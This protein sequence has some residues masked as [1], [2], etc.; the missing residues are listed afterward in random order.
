MLEKVAHFN[1]LSEGLRE[2]LDKRISEFGKTVRYK[3]NIG[4]DNP[5]PEKKN[6]KILY[7]F[8]YT[9]DP[10]VFDINDTDEKDK[11]KSKRKKIGIIKSVDEKGL[12]TAFI[13]IKLKEGQ[14]GVLELRTTDL[15]ELEMI[16]L[17]ELH[18][19]QKGGLF[20]N[21]NFYQLFER[22]DEK[23]YNKEKREE[24]S[25]KLKAQQLAMKMSEKEVRQFADAMLW[26]STEE[27]EILRGLVEDLAE[28]SPSLFNDLV[29]GKAVE[30]QAAIKQAMDKKIISFDPA[31]YKF[32][33]CANQQ[34]LA[35]LTQSEDKNEVQ[36][37]SEWMQVNGGESF[38]KLKSLLAK[39]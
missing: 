28:N 4:R 16:A 35:I 1:D 23:Q 19:K 18:P 20:A 9:L 36:K 37:L 8:Q 24:R 34:P 14:R 22:V 13:K 5:D 31:E 15:D 27:L 39:S 25:V 30:Y 38:N 7:P 21:D 11:S 2:K 26:E 29:E 6:G 33:W 32:I 12:P 17:L 3:F 10:S